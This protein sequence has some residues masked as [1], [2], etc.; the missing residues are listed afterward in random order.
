MKYSECKLPIWDG[1]EILK[2]DISKNV[3][4]DK[5]AICFTA[6]HP[7]NHKRLFLKKHD[8]CASK[9]KNLVNYSTECC[10]MFPH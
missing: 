9:S 7:E 1:Q 5:K 6:E 10:W 3:L 8:H 4:F 2:F